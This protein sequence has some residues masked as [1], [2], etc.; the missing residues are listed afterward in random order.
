[1]RCEFIAKRFEDGIHIEEYLFMTSHLIN[2][3]RIGFSG[4]VPTCVIEPP[5]R[6]RCKSKNC[7][8]ALVQMLYNALMHVLKFCCFTSAAI[9]IIL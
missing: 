8:E 4:D 7:V 6:V 9:L 1:M 2:I 3:V 5:V